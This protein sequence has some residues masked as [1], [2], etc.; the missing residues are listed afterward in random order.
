[1][2]IMQL[3]GETFR[4]ASSCNHFF[5]EPFISYSFHNNCGKRTRLVSRGQFSIIHQYFSFLGED[6]N[7]DSYRKDEESSS[8]GTPASMSPAASPSPSAKVYSRNE[9]DKEVDST[10]L[11]DC[12]RGQHSPSSTD[13]DQPISPCIPYVTSSSAVQRVGNALPQTQL[14]VLSKIF[15]AYPTDLLQITLMEARGSVSQAVEKVLYGHGQRMRRSTS[16]RTTHPSA[17][18]ETERY[19]CGLA[20]LSTLST[21][22]RYCNRCGYR[23]FATDNFCSTCGCILRRC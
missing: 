17:F 5:V 11:I 4:Y 18:K 15:P 6:K 21:L 13:S 3:L 20:T 1:M 23:A 8:T 22:I 14:E 9:S 2:A 19:D 12:A 10:E 16:L 7:R